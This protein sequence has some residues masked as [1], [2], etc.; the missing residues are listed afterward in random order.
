MGEERKRRRRKSLRAVSEPPRA[1][2]EAFAA[3][4][5]NLIWE[6]KKKGE[7]GSEGEREGWRERLLLK[8]GWE[9]RHR[10]DDDERRISSS[11]SFLVHYWERWDQKRERERE[12]G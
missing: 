8:E 4:A 12:M 1:E 11:H 10:S 5:E 7:K 9:G 3:A 2:E 6:G